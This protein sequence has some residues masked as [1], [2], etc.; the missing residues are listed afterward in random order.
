MNKI[1]NLF[2]P[3][4]LVVLLCALVL[5]FGLQAQQA[6]ANETEETIRY[7]DTIYYF[8]DYYPTIR[9]SEMEKAYTNKNIVYDRS[10]DCSYSNF[11]NYLGAYGYFDKFDSSCMVIIDIK[12]FKPEAA[13]LLELFTLL[14]EQGC[15]TMFISTYEEGAFSGGEFFEYVDRFIKT[16][17]TRLE[18]FIDELLVDER[19]TDETITNTAF[20]IDGNLVD[21]HP[22]HF[23]SAEVLCQQS[24][25]LRIFME[26]LYYIIE[27][28][29][30]IGILTIDDFLRYLDMINV[31]VFV[32]DV[33]C[34]TYINIYTGNIYTGDN[35]SDC[36]NAT[37]KVYTKAC[38]IGFWELPSS[39]YRFLY[40]SIN[41]SLPVNNYV[42][43]ADPI[44]Y[45]EGGLPI[46]TD[47]DLLEVDEAE[48]EAL[49][50]L[51]SIYPD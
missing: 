1:K 46:I 8:F 10:Q 16:D 39:F 17:F 47:K 2:I 37:E 40:N 13:H 24:L 14:K 49:A 38:S 9:H 27:C 6:N 28:D 26:R 29:N 7:S 25:F 30:I 42:M 34:D 22:D 44:V 31:S 36:L 43:E 50:I 19:G 4:L 18:D 12:M 11:T 32:H 48:Q 41:L 45:V 35:V 21:I 15:C 33:V 23:Q 20:F 51:Q 3:I 5:P